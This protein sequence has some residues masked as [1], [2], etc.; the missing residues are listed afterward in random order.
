MGELE[1]V[2]LAWPTVGCFLIMAPP[3]PRQAERK[4]AGHEYTLVQ[5]GLSPQGWQGGS[6]PSLGGESLQLCPAPSRTS[7]H[8]CGQKD[9]EEDGGFVLVTATTGLTWAALP[10][11]VVA[12]DAGQS[13]RA[14]GSSGPCDAHV[15][16]S[17]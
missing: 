13:C 8:I 7:R 17:E 9:C 3:P 12:L 16:A 2:L 15:E 10:V 14:L 11:R 6:C 1:A 4:A 5:R